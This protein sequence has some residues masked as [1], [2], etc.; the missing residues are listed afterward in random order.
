MILRLLFAAILL[1]SIGAAA[2]DQTPTPTPIPE[3]TAV[4]STPAP[5]P[6]D[7][8]GMP[9]DPMK[10]CTVVVNPLQALSLKVQQID[11]GASRVI[12]QQQQQIQDLNRRLSELEKSGK[13]KK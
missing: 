8:S 3:P 5:A 7:A 12:Q 1:C 10:P 2:A 13:A 6:C 4:E 11:Q 9:S